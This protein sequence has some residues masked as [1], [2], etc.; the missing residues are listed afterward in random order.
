MSNCI[1][2][3][4]DFEVGKKYKCCNPECT[5]YICFE[6]LKRYIEIASQENS[7]PTCPREKCTGVFDEKTLPKEFADTFRQLLHR[8]FN[9]VKKG[10]I[11]EFKKAVFL[12]EKLKNEKTQFMIDSMPAAVKKVAQIAFAGRL[13][14]I[15]KVQEGREKDR[16]SRTCLNLVCNGFLDETF[17]CT[18]CKV[19]FCKECE[20]EKSDD[21]TCD[22]NAVESVKFVNGMVSCP[23]CKT[24][25]EKGEGCM[26]I[27]C[28]VCHTNF[29]Y[30]TGKKGDSGNHGQYVD[31]RI[32][33]FELLSSAFK[34][35]IPPVYV[36]YITDLEQ[37]LI[38]VRT[39]KTKEAFE[40]LLFNDTDNLERFSKKYSE[41]VRDEISLIAIAKKLAFLEKI[42]QKCEFGYE[43][44][45]KALFNE[46]GKIAV[47]CV[48]SSDDKHLVVNDPVIFENMIDAMDNMKVS[49]ID[50]RKA[51]EHNGGV[52]RGFHWSYV[53]E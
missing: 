40:K 36:G 48:I 13:K 10:E 51:I 15:K 7:L 4:T 42:L 20:T 44:K 35:R 50:V 41:M 38:K 3:L 24:K 47:A 43:E 11:S 37:T 18:T 52:Y 12:R 19:S 23:S 2:C 14:K 32:K 26:A 53:D 29:W 30:T 6:C 34:D 1:I 45:I 5:E 31:V 25:I 49:S 8:H 39:A 16:V 22:P 17:A 27:T 9:L 28:A 21:H 46:Q 33:N